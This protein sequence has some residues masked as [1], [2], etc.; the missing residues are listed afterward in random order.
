MIACVTFDFDGTLVDSNQVKVQSFYKIVESYDPSGC[1]VTEILQRCSHK[2][3][4]G[5]TCELAREFMAKGL[6][7]PHTGTEVLGLQLAETYT[8]TCETAVVGC[9]EVPGASGILL[10][11]L[12][13]EIPLYLNSRTPATALNR[14]VTLRNLTHYFAGIYGA[15][16]SKLENLLHIQELTQ[17]KP[18]EI[19]FVGDS[20]DD[21]K[22]AAEFGC[23]FAGVILGG[24]SR[25]TQIPPLHMTNL[26]E[27]KAIVENLQGKRNGLPKPLTI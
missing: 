11:L 13:Q 25:F 8:N 26:A 6:I 20:E 1:I 10:W 9:P 3:R 16:A 14:L 21:R 19:L 22:A 7:P 15:P 4:Y 12:N 24:N 5:I 17:A 2:D 23:H 27:L 18:E